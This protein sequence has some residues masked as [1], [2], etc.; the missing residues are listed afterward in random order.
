MS[1]RVMSRLQESKKIF[2]SRITP[3]RILLAILS[4]VSFSFAAC[5]SDIGD[6]RASGCPSLKNYT[7]EQ[8]RRAA[9]EIRKNPNT[10]LAALVRDYGLMR[11]A[12]RVK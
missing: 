3:S 11:K 4:L 12:C 10:E 1:V 7:A 9:A 5:N 8:Q 2:W 6:Y